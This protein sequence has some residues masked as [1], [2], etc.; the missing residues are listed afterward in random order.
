MGE[1]DY[2]SLQTYHIKTGNLT[3]EFEL[4]EGECVSDNA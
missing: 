3:F 1:S 2:T 4:G